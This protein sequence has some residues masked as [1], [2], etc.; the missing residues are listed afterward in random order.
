MT[1]LPSNAGDSGNQESDTEEVSV[2]SMEEIYEPSGELETEKD[3]E[4]DDKVE[5]PLPT[6]IKRRRQELPRC[7]RVSG[8]EKGFQQEE[9]NFR[10]NLSGLEENSPDQ[11]WKN[12]FPRTYWTTFFF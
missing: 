7:K 12:L 4:S 2:K 6:P 1:V 11:M 10:E 9:P 8:F 3:L 5:L